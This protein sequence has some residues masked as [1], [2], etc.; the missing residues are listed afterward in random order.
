MKKCSKCKTSKPLEDFYTGN[1]THGRYAYCVECE[2]RRK[3]G[4]Y[5]KD[6][7]KIL[8][9]QHEKRGGR[10]SEPVET[11]RTAFHE[12]VRN[13]II[14][15]SDLA[16]STLAKMM[17]VG[18]GVILQQRQYLEEQ[19][20]IPYHK[21][22]KGENGKMRRRM[23]RRKPTQKQ[24]FGFDEVVYFVQ[25]MEGGPIKIGYTNNL[26][27][28]LRTMQC[29]SPSILLVLAYMP[30]TPHIEA[31]LHLQY[32]DLKVRKTGCGREWFYPEPALMSFISEIQS[33]SQFELIENRYI[34]STECGTNLKSNRKLL[35]CA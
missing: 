32:D 11:L 26:D 19:G 23:D 35:S 24:V 8:A 7:N 27:S 25:G 33:R 17:N 30:G 18:H 14:A 29:G 21:Y 3:G 2:R 28:R 10:Y 5:E 1:G 6:K 34:Y 22:L 20:L 9:A 13:T 31:G 4:C 15:H 16:N 12:G